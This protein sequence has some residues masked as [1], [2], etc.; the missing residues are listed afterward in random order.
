MRNQEMIDDSEVCVFYF[1][2]NY[3]PPIRKPSNK[4]LPNYQPKSGTAIAFAYA[5]QKK[6]QIYN[7]FLEEKSN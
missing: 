6:K 5:T 2:H 1:N 4:F 3:L 7:T